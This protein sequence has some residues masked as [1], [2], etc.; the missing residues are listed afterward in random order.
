M[1]DFSVKAWKGKVVAWDGPGRGCTVRLLGKND[2]ISGVAGEDIAFLVH[3]DEVEAR[4]EDGEF[5]LVRGHG[6]RRPSGMT[7]RLVDTQR[8]PS[9][10][11]T[12]HGVELVNEDQA[13]VRQAGV[14]GEPKAACAFACK[15]RALSGSSDVREQVKRECPSSIFMGVCSFWSQDRLLYGFRL[16]YAGRKMKFGA[17]EDENEAALAAT[18]FL[19]R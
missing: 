13:A 6:E 9:A 1:L 16:R 7:P 2:C 4:M 10:A 12:L 14:G 3:Q 18:L 5:S 17:F 15:K 19:R 11:S 8:D